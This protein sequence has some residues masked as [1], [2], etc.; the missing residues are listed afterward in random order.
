MRVIRKPLKKISSQLYRKL[1]FLNFRNDG[2]MQRELTLFR[3]KGQGVVH[4]ILD[5]TKLI[6][7]SLLFRD[8]VFRK[9]D[10]LRCRFYTRRH[11][12]R[13]GYGRQL[14]LANV[15]Y[16]KQQRTTFRVGIHEDDNKEFFRKCKKALKC[17]RT[18]NVFG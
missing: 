11:E 6:G 16:V 10:G 14:L 1:Y 12:R 2:S 5:G 15:R 3:K 8:S 18:R 9:P 7:W 4:Y 17:K 13:K